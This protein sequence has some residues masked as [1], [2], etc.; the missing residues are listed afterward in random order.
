MPVNFIDRDWSSHK[1]RWNV[2][3]GVLRNPSEPQSQKPPERESPRE[4]GQEESEE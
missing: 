3:V 2:S 4:E 1:D